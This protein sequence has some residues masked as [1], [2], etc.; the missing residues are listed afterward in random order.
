[1]IF[2]GT[3]QFISTAQL[4]DPGKIYEVSDE[5]ES[6][7]FV[8]LYEGI[9]RVVHNKPAAL[10]AKFIFD[11]ARA[12]ANGR[13]TGGIGKQNMYG[14]NA[15]VILEELKFEMSPPFTNLIRG[16]FCL[17]QSLYFVNLEKKS[18]RKPRSEDAANI[19]KLKDCKAVIQL[20]KKAVKR[21]DWPKE[22]D[23]VLDDNYPRDGEIDREDRV[24]LANLKEV[25][26]PGD[27]PLPASPAPAAS[28]SRVSK[29][30][31]EEDDGPATPTK[32]SKVEAV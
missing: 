29:R 13:Q 1:M 15:E 3:W 27:V 16:L 21:K 32:R 7:F 6:F 10:N 20:M 31:R 30:G 14:M 28:I 9:H 19:E 24:G 8:I 25:T 5:L 4:S 18:K 22:H 17:F 23:K 26:S 11:D 12:D 2:Q